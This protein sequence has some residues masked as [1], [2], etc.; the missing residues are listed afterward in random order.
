MTQ[1]EFD[2]EAHDERVNRRFLELQKTAGRV[3]IFDDIIDYYLDGDATYEEAIDQFKQDIE[4]EGIG[5][6]EAA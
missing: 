4:R 2:F 5:Y 1:P 6:E 3:A